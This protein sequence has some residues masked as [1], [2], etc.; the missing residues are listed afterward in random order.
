MKEDEKMICYLRHS[1][2]YVKENMYFKDFVDFNNELVDHCRFIILDQHIGYIKSPD[3]K[4][5][6]KKFDEMNPSDQNEIE[7]L[8]NVQ[9]ARTEMHITKFLKWLKKSTYL[10][11]IS[12]FWLY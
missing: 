1:R 5:D 9:L 3:N 8:L 2:K 7:T 4:F 12:I 6:K 10:G 11:F